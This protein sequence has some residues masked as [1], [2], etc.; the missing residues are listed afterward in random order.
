MPSGSAQVYNNP[1]D[2][3]ASVQAT[4][5]KLTLTARGDFHAHRIGVGAWI[6]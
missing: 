6:G 1:E 4:M 2:Y 3:A 5:G